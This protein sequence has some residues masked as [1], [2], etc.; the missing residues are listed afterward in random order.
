MYI[1]KGCGRTFHAPLLLGTDN[2]AGEESVYV[3][4]HCRNMSYAEAVWCTICDKWYDQDA[5]PV[6]E[7]VCEK[8]LYQYYSS[9]LAVD[10]LLK[11]LDE[12]Q[13]FKAWD[14][15]EDISDDEFAE[16]LRSLRTTAWDNTSRNKFLR[17]MHEYMLS[18]RYWF[19]TNVLESYIDKYNIDLFLDAFSMDKMFR[20]LANDWDLYFQPHLLFADDYYGIDKSTGMMAESLLYYLQ[21]Q[22]KAEN[23]TFGGRIIED[24]KN[25]LIRFVRNRPE[26]GI[27]YCIYCEDTRHE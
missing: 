20:F 18:D 15:I 1:C 2:D 12:M 3:C 5:T 9:Y 14:G 23:N 22:I 26:V 7:G 17:K 11:H 4:P 10:Y 19:V 27:A 8:C 6:N 21:A 16:R 24:T 25:R 13:T